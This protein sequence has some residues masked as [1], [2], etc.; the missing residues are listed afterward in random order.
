MNA[1][2]AFPKRTAYR[3]ENER[4]CP[5]KCRHSIQEQKSKQTQRTR[6]CTA[7]VRDR[8]WSELETVAA[9]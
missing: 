1:T 8:R 9:K 4:R 5:N 2:K 6:V 7:M 3:K